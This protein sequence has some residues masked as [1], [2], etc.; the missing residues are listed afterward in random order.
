MRYVYGEGED[1]YVEYEE[2]L[3]GSPMPGPDGTLY[4]QSDHV[5][6]GNLFVMDKYAHLE[7]LD[8]ILYIN[9][10]NIMLGSN[11]EMFIT[12]APGMVGGG[13]DRHSLLKSDW[14][15]NVRLFNQRR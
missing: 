11:S 12:I 7:W 6:S 15:V 2:V 1:D 9:E 8:P 5:Y 13:I 10:G 3:I 4:G 14:S